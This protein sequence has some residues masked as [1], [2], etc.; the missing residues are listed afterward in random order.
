[1][2][3]LKKYYQEKIAPELKKALK[4]D[5][6]LALPKIE[7]I[8][9]NVGVG[10]YLQESKDNLEPI[11]SDFQA[12]V[13]QKPVYIKSNRAISG[14]KLKIGD[15]VGIK[16]TLRN[17]RMYDFLEKLIKIAM[18][19]IKDFRGIKKSAIDKYGNINIGIKEHPVFPEIRIEE[20][21][22]VFSFQINISTT[23][24]NKKEAELLLK[25]FG[26]VF[27]K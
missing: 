3:Y 25:E 10:K 12:I 16:A 19:R 5:N 22:K 7:K 17:Q 11:V 23:A 9:I 14:F 13:G 1:M 20:V 15:I 24:K 18:P 6:F 2:S 27:E 4:K 21:K 8:T 26:A